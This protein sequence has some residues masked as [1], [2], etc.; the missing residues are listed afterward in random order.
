MTA[1]RPG[2]FVLSADIAGTGNF[3][4]IGRMHTPSPAFAAAMQDLQNGAANSELREVQEH[5]IAAHVTGLCV[6]GPEIEAALQN[7]LPA[8]LVS[9][10]RIVLPGTGVLQAL[11]LVTLLRPAKNAPGTLELSLQLA[12]KPAFYAPA[13]VGTVC[14]G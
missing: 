13:P 4:E 3:I 11:F 8:R 9:E 12:G 6:L 5:T 1:R 7:F 14:G 10:W 2:D